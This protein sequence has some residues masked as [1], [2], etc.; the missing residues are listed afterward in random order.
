MGIGVMIF[1]DKSTRAGFFN[2]NVFQKQLQTANEIDPYRKLLSP[3]C[4]RVMDE[5][6]I[7][8]QKF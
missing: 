5:F 2:K 6:I 1:P 4:L 7:K 8:R 3:D